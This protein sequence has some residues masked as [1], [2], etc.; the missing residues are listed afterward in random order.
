M[1]NFNY[2]F[3]TLLTIIILGNFI[4]CTDNNLEEL[5][6]NNNIEV[7]NIEKKEIKETDI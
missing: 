3:L 2:L 7:H 4:S 6:L 5:N 1:K